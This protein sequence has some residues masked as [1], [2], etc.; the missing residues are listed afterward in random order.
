M[1]IENINREKQ[2]EKVN[3]PELLKKARKMTSKEV[4]APTWQ[5]VENEAKLAGITLKDKKEGLDLRVALFA[6]L[7]D[8]F[9]GY[10]T[11][12]HVGGLPD[13]ELFAEVLKMV[14][15]AETQEQSFEQ[16]KAA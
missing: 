13:K 4:D 8:T 3:Y 10:N 11:T 12:E 5:H 1:K 16:S 2:K 7:R 9:A 14:E 6:V 15:S